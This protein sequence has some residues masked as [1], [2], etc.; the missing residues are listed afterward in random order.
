MRILLIAESFGAGVFEVV[1]ALAERLAANGHDVAIA[2][3]IRP[4]PR[5]ARR[6]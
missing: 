6:S 4:R 1:R 5:S 2:Y 3:G